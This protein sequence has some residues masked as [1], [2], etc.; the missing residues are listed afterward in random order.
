M[1]ATLLV[2]AQLVVRER[3][4]AGC[5]AVMVESSDNESNNSKGSGDFDSDL[6]ALAMPP[7]GKPD[8]SS[9]VRR[10]LD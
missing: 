3:S 10:G 9:V 6:A 4:V 8:R 2:A 5:C 1:L 7:P